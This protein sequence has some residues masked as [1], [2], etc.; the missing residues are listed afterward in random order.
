MDIRER[1]PFSSVNRDKIFMLRATFLVGGGRI[2]SK[3]ALG[4][5][6]GVSHT[7]IKAIESGQTIN[8]SFNFIIEYCRFFNVSPYEIM[9]TE[10]GVE[11]LD[12]YLG[13]LIKEEIIS[14]EA[15]SKIKE[16]HLKKR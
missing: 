2:L 7:N 9:Q 16:F 10:V 11:L 6:L 3:R 8:P 5:M 4:D 15:A 12:N 1:F 13:K 14:A